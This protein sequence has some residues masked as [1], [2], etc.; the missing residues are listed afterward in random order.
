MGIVNAIPAFQLYTA[1]HTYLDVSAPAPLDPGWHRLLAWFNP[2]V[3]AGLIVDLQ[4][5]ISL[6]AP[7]A[8]DWEAQ[9]EFWIN[10]GYS[11]PTTAT[12]L[13]DIALWSCLLTPEEF[14]ADFN[15]SPRARAVRAAA[16]PI[17]PGPATWQTLY[18][19]T[20]TDGQLCY[21]RR[22]PL[23]TAP[24]RGQWCLTAEPYF[25]LENGWQLPWYLAFQWKPRPSA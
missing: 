1:A 12:Y 15:A 4:D 5:A 19:S 20:P 22:C 9:V 18:P 16:M 10:Y 11:G 8:L 24:F 7:S 3:D 17:N 25:M 14:L 13:D 23:D 21:V 6:P 2:G